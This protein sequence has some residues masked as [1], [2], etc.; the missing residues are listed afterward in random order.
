VPAQVGSVESGFVETAVFP[1]EPM[2]D[3]FFE[4]RSKTTSARFR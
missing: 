2:L 4:V 1:I 3:G